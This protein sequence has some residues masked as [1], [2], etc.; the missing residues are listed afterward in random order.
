MGNFVVYRHTS[1]SGKVYIGITCQNPEQRWQNGN[2]YKNNEYFARAIKKYGWDNFEHEILYRELSKEEAERIEI[3]L[4]AKHKS[5]EPKNGYNI[6]GGGYGSA[7]HSEETKKRI[8]EAK[9]GVSIWDEEARKKMSEERRGINHPR[10]GTHWTEEQK[11]MLSK[12]HKGNSVGEKNFWYGKHGKN[13]P[14]SKPVIMYDL[15]TK[16]DLQKFDSI[17]DACAVMGTDTSCIAKCCKGKYA[18]S[19][20]YGWRYANE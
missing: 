9:K 10:Y 12:A 4:I 6:S 19:H 2:G 13:N 20:G 17:S 18:S 8:S 15:I 11:K 5:T 3:E 7:H 14:L 1:P 16:E